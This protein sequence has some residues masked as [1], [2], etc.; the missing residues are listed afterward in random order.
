MLGSERL[1]RFMLLIIP[2][3]GVLVMLGGSFVY[4]GGENAPAVTYLSGM[5][6]LVIALISATATLVPNYPV[7]MFFFG[8]V[9]MKWIAAGFIAIEVVF[10]G[11]LFSPLS[12]AVLL[13]AG[14]G[15]GFVYL[16]RQGTDVVEI[17]SSWFARMSLLAEHQPRP[18]AKCAV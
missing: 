13:A 18:E 16:M 14:M 4:N 7:P 15:Y 8:N 17:V 5:M 2:L 9:A 1:R 6:P 10:S 11:F 3:I 12:W